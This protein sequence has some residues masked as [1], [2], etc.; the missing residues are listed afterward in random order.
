VVEDD[1]AVQPDPG[2]GAVHIGNAAADGDAYRGWFVG[3]FVAPERAG[4][5]SSEVEVKW[6]VHHH[7]EVRGA[8]ATSRRATSLSLLVQ[9]AIR[10]EFSGGRQALLAQPGDYAVWPPGVAHRWR[11]EAEPTIIVTVRWPSLPGDAVDLPA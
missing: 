11:I 9:G 6:G 8:W 4:C 7:G 2:S 5:A 10:L 1:S 3:H